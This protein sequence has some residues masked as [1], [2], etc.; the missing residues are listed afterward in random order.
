MSPELPYE[1]RGGTD[2]RSSL[3]NRIL[4]IER[5]KY[6]SNVDLRDKST[7]YKYL[8]DCELYIRFYKDIPPKP[9]DE[10]YC[11]RAAEIV[12]QFEK[13][14]KEDLD[15]SIDGATDRVKQLYHESKSAIRI[16]PT[17]TPLK[18]SERIETLLEKIKRL[19]RNKHEMVGQFFKCKT[20][21][22]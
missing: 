7:E 5:I 11:Q 2:E 8:L 18:D 14:K 10:E 17:E 4:A 3:Y 12:K 1:A 9:V 6:L 16:E 22:V 15:K 19:F 20:K 21:N 13:E